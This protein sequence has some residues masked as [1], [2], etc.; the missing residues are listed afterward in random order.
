MG[1]KS[2]VAIGLTLAASIALAGTAWAGPATVKTTPASIVIQGSGNGSAGP[3]A[4]DQAY[5]VVKA[6]YQGEQY[7]MLQATY[8]VKLGGSD[9]E[10]NLVFVQSGAEVM[11]VFQND[12][13]QGQ[14]SRSLTFQVQAAG[15]YTIELLK[16]PA[17]TGALG[18]PQTFKGGKGWMM[19]PLVKT[20]GNYVMLCLQWTGAVDPNKKGG[21]P[22]ASANLYDAET[23][24]NWVRNQSVYNKNTK[25]D[26]GYTAKKPGV[27]FA[28]VNSGKDG[29]SWEVSILE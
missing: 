22:L 13:A 24:D 14:A 17:L 20:K 18:A 16:P 10:K 26:D 8:K 4:L 3:V 6:K 7:S 15:P 23:G 28:L 2:K 25:S 19:T 29:G 9:V 21:L 5:Y 12:R 11:S 1:T 27:Y